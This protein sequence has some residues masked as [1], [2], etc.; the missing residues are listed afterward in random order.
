MQRRLQERSAAG[1]RGGSRCPGHSADQ[2]CDWESRWWSMGT[3]L[4]CAQREVTVV[5]SAKQALT[6]AV[7]LSEVGL[8]AGFSEKQPNLLWQIRG[9]VCFSKGWDQAHQRVARISHCGAWDGAGTA[10][11]LKMLKPTRF[12][13]HPLAPGSLEPGLSEALLQAGRSR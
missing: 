1:H 7:F 2:G 11:P 12:T 8:Y 5:L 3:R 13:K 10:K 9:R 4:L 6:Q